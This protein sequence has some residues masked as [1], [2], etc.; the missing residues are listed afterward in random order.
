VPKAVALEFVMFRQPVSTGPETVAG[1]LHKVVAVD[2]CKIG[3]D[4]DLDE[5]NVE[6]D[7]VVTT[8]P[9]SAVLSYRKARPKKA[10]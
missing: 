2:G 8:V 9:R 4:Y 10:E 5:V 1:M 7:G 6:R 3:L